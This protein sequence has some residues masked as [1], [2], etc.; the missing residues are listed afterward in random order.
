MTIGPGPAP[1]DP[2][3]ETLRSVLEGRNLG[4]LLDLGCGDGSFIDELL[5]ISDA[6]EVW[7]LD[8]DEDA[9]SEAKRYF[10]KAGPQIPYYLFTGSS[11]SP[12]LPRDNFTTVSF[13]DMLHHL[14][15]GNFSHQ[16]DAG[17]HS[18]IEAH[19]DN[20]DR[21]LA[22]GGVMIIS[23]YIVDR[24]NPPARELRVA[25]HNFKA[26]IDSLH[27]ISHSYSISAAWLENFIGSWMTSRG[28]ESLA[29]RFIESQAAPVLP[30]RKDGAVEK[31]LEFFTGYLS[32]IDDPKLGLDVSPQLRRR[33]DDELEG[34]RR[35]ALEHGLQGQRRFVCAAR[36]PGGKTGV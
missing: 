13:Q 23:E 10:T 24:R 12:G 25:L 20:A 3:E 22:P 7:G 15:G 33:L 17:L 11:L 26:Q 36:K 29:Q 32:T 18:A 1:A 9:V 34:I 5:N 31:A 14:S 16:P 19:F 27:G 35:G 4:A 30:G 8:P 28:Y 2:L 21:L 6:R